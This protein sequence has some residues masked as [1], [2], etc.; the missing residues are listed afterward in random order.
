MC[1]LAAALALALALPAAAQPAPVEPIDDLQWLFIED[2]VA[3]IQP[4]NAAAGERAKALMAE[5]ATAR[6]A[7]RNGEM[8]R[9]LAEARVV[10][11]GG[12]WTPEAAFAASLAI[13]PH[14]TVVDPTEPLTVEIGQRFAAA[15]PGVVGPLT[16][17]LGIRRWLGR[18]PKPEPTMWLARVEPLTGDLIDQPAIARL[19]LADAADD[20]YELVARARRGSDDMGQS[21]RRFFVVA[22]LRRDLA[23]ID[24]RAGK[25]A[26]DG[27]AKAS[28]VY[29]SDLVRTLDDG[30][31]QVRDVAFRPLLDHAM[32]L[33]DAA[34]SGANPLPPAAGDQ[35]RHYRLKAAE[36][37]EPYRL[38]IPA[39]WDGRSALPL[40]VALHGS[41]G[42]HHSMLA[43]GK[44]AAA[45]A[46]RGWA[47][48]SP[49]GY[50]PNSGW[51]NHL[52]V[53]LANGTMP[54]PR[55]STIAGV[56]LPRDGV[57]PEPAEEDVLAALADVRAHYPI[58]ARRIYLMG[59]SM[60]GEG[61]W[62]LAARHP[63]LWAAAAPGAGA[64]A[65]DLYDYRALG[66][67][68]VLGVHGDRD[69]IISF[70][71]TRNMVERLKAAGGDATML[72]I[73]GGGHS[74]MSDATDTIL[75]FFARH[76]RSAPGASGP[77]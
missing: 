36:R 42:D 17:D 35:E 51:G 55:P 4:P 2:T 5:A 61:T 72:A 63:R 14:S 11:A 25:L 6:A 64:I 57:N 33:L 19:S 43:S 37:Y 27:A 30:S 34:E 20:S 10:L 9:A 22:G 15:A 45:V 74:A 49:M 32:R 7:G 77:R 75:E 59:N 65:P 24:A 1:A 70:D 71:A 47:V 67:L 21:V 13:R 38:V 54:A 23:A 44:L 62:H 31:R 26:L 52:P 56:V 73:A 8:R 3:L 40:V 18:A 12:K 66:R 46:R 28:I 50:S 68:P 29:P 53:V 16:I 41:A 60:G 58:D 48:L 69:P 76:R 39:S